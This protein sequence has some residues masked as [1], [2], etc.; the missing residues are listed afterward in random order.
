M[1]IKITKEELELL[2]YAVGNMG[3]MTVMFEASETV[4]GDLR[5]SSKDFKELA[6]KLK[7]QQ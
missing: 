7:Q 5:Y 6:A 2:I 4:K 3:S 1:N